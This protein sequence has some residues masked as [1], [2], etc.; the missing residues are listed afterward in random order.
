MTDAEINVAIAEACGWRECRIEVDALG[1]IG[2]GI[3]P[4]DFERSRVPGFVHDLN[5][6]HEAE[7]ALKD[8]EQWQYC[9]NVLIVVARSIPRATWMEA[10]HATAAEKAE[11]F[12]RTL[13]LWKEQAEERPAGQMKG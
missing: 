9:Q 8:D 5:A 2:T 13:G 11:A 10:L 12:V 4:N 6:M 3:S 7:R 1:V